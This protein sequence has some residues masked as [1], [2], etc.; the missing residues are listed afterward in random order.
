MHVVAGFSPRSGYAVFLDQQEF[1]GG[2]RSDRLPL[3]WQS[4]AVNEVDDFDRRIRDPAA[5]GAKR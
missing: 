2:I 1:L 5:L 3:L 4:Q